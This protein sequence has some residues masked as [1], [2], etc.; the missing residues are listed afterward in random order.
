MKRR[1][2][3]ILFIIY[4][5]LHIPGKCPGGIL[6]D[7]EAF[8]PLELDDK[9]TFD[10]FFREFPPEVS[11]LTFTNLFIWR[12]VYHPRWAIISECLCIVSCPPNK[13]MFFYSPIGLNPLGAIKEISRNFRNNRPSLR[14]ERIPEPLA[15]EVEKTADLK[16]RIAYDRANCDY[17]YEIDALVALSGSKLKDKRKKYN[18]FLQQYPQYE[19]K[20]CE[21]ILVEDCR[22]IQEKWYSSMVLNDDPSLEAEHIAVEQAF[23]HHEELG[24]DGG[25]IFVDGKPIAFT[26]GEALN[27]NTVVIHIEKADLAFEGSYQAINQMFLERSTC[28]AKK[29]Y[30]NREQDLGLPGLRRAKQSYNPVKL[31]GKYI[32]E[33]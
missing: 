10:K 21:T 20:T 2:I 12:G 15:K 29:V 25:V 18:R 17:L 16:V 1:K 27:P 13:S 4:F 22:K 3:H 14:F 24:F 31:V 9:A 28:A 5:E 19:Y 32:V 26:L 8:K 33:F 6:M 11:E 23:D 30:V 7:Y